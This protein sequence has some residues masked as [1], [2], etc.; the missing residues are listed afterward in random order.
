MGFNAFFQ[1]SFTRAGQPRTPQALWT[2]GPTKSPEWCPHDGPCK[3]KSS[4]ST[5]HACVAQ[6]AQL[7][8]SNVLEV[9]SVR[10]GSLQPE[11]D[12]CM[13]QHCS[14]AYNLTFVCKKHERAWQPSTAQ[15]KSR[16]CQT[17]WFQKASE[18]LVCG[19]AVQQR[20][21]QD[22][23][24]KQS[25]VASAVGAHAT[26]IARSAACACRRCFSISALVRP[27]GNLC[28]RSENLKTVLDIR[29]ASSRV[30]CRR[31]NTLGQGPHAS[32]IRSRW[33]AGLLKS[34]LGLANLNPPFT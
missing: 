5:L 21:P 25:R 32:H 26:S 29:P 10:R 20:L 3:Q 15:M 12:S 13:A 23:Q 14:T 2:A 19:N 6:A 24:C 31:A 27:S 18:E 11:T 16:E 17:A 30:I 9:K 8:A 33:P 1:S 34:R 4:R 7:S 28:W 22:A